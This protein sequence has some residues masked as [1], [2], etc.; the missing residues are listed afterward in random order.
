[1][2]TYFQDIHNFDTL[3]STDE[4]SAHCEKTLNNNIR[5]F[6]IYKFKVNGE[7]ANIIGFYDGECPAETE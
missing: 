5:L 1:M 6:A 4:F 7:T 2:K 3:M